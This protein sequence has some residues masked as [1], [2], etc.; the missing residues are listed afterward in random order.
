MILPH[1]PR[2]TNF[3]S[4]FK[5]PIRLC[6]NGPNGLVTDGFNTIGAL[7]ALPPHPGV[8]GVFAVSG[9]GSPEC[10]S[11][12]RLEYN[13]NHIHVIAIDTIS[14]GF[15]LSLG[16]M[17]ELTGGNAVA[18]DSVEAFATQVGQFHCGL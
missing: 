12:W 11:C 16:A 17:N 5:Y 14:D 18:L 13:G 2:P 10:G 15:D 8:G 7:T 4:L 9:W 6:S 1:P 3:P